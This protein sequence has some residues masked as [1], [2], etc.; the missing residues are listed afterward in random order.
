MPQICNPMYVHFG[1][2]KSSI[3]NKS[4]PQ[5]QDE[6]SEHDGSDED[7]DEDD[8]EN[9]SSEDEDSASDNDNL[10]APLPGQVVGIV[11]RD[12]VSEAGYKDD[13]LVGAS[14]GPARSRRPLPR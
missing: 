5:S 12:A 6:D 14:R 13:S 11:D 3:T 8:N 2:D 9:A 4:I 1:T 10:A 7:E